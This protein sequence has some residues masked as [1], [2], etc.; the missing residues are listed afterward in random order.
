MHISDILQRHPTT[1]S[2]EF[3]PPKTPEGFEALVLR[4]FCLRVS[5]REIAT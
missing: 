1:F 3:F 5:Q 2:F 4:D